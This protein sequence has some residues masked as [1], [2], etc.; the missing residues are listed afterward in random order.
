M[1]PPRCGQ[2]LMAPQPGAQVRAPLGLLSFSGEGSGLQLV[3]APAQPR[4]PW[5]M[6]VQACF[7]VRVTWQE[8]TTLLLRADL[9]TAANP[10]ASPETGEHLEAQL[11]RGGGQVLALGTD[12]EAQLQA[13]LR[14]PALRAQVDYG[15]RSMALALSQLPPGPGELTWRI[16]WN[17]DPEPVRN[18]CW[19]AVGVTPA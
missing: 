14:H 7:V 13:R 17:P 2:Q 16:A 4:L 1:G 12:D 10:T 6:H 18:T 9:S 5:G 15:A 11:W 3:A 19:F 8:A